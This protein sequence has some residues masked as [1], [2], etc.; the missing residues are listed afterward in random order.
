MRI[1]PIISL[2]LSILVGI[3]AVF[4][5]R[6]WINKE[7]QASGNPPAEIIIEKVDTQRILVADLAI[8]RGDLLTQEAFRAVEWPIGHLPAG[9]ITDISAVTSETGGLPYALGL[10]VP[11]EP[12]LKGKLSHKAVRDALPA[13]IEPGFR[14]MSVEVN[15]VTGV[16]GFVLPEHRVDVNV[17]KSRYDRATDTQVPVAETLL[18]NI[19]VLAVDQKFQDNLEGAAPARTVTLQVTPAQARRL[20]LAS[21][22]SD[23]GLVLRA[24]GDD[25]IA[26]ENPRPRATPRPVI[27][28]APVKAA[29]KFANIRVIQ[30]DQEENVSAPVARPVDDGATDK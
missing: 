18:Q 25:P 13:L 5:G 9:A 20:G 29:P 11:G 24:K 26:I 6:G 14:A 15:D 2:V 30:G 12:L 3:A 27:R 1:A 7:A 19:R 22:N 28:R 10:I 16:A 21:E 8:E 23:I 4:I 17:F